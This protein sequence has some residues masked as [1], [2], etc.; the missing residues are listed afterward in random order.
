MKYKKNQYS[1]GFSICALIIA[2]AFFYW[3]Y[4][5]LTDWRYGFPWWG[6]IALA[7]GIAITASQIAALA[8]RGKL[9]NTVLYEY[10]EN[11]NASIEEISRKTGISEKDVRAITLDL[12]GTGRLRGSFSTSTGTFKAI[13][14]EHKE[15]AKAAYCPGCGTPL[16]NEGAQF[17]GFCGY[18]IE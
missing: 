5:N 6:F 18:K 1:E 14:P 4:T 7:I 12:K 13:K 15:E 9:R 2:G 11:P 16:K 10:Q 3:A 8:N 17:C